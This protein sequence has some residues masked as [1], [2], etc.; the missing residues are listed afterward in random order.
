MAY[1]VNAPFGLK[2]L[3]S[4]HGGT[5]SG[6]TNTYYI[7]ASAD[8]GTTQTQS[9]FTGDPV[10]WSHKVVAGAAPEINTIIPYDPDFTLDA[11]S[12]FS[13]DPIVGVFQGCEYF[14][15]NGTL[16]KS[17]YWEGDT[18]VLP[19]S[20]IK[21]FVMDDPDMVCEIQVSTL[22][23][24]NANAFV[25]KPIFPNINASSLELTGG[26]GG[27]FA[28]AIGGG[29]H[30][31]TVENPN[32]GTYANNPASGNRANGQSAYYLCVTTSTIAAGND[33]DYNKIFNT[34]GAAPGLLGRLALKAIGW[35]DNVQNQPLRSPF[36]VGGIPTLQTTPFLNVK[37]LI[38]NHAYGC[39]SIGARYF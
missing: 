21:A 11:P 5:W 25:G 9:I 29:A 37:V 26:F 27:N 33:A 19:G 14:L 10:Q 13:Y 1:G 16:V 22:I 23:D 15:P 3:Y 36:T 7:Y 4:I 31:S 39:N 2:P 38:N 34:E 6:G 17:P 30:F 24:A 20:V 18:K 12:K 28:I 35:S 8:G 32:G